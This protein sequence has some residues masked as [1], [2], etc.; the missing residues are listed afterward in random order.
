M[1]LV[2]G[3]GQWTPKVPHHSSSKL[4][5]LPHDIYFS[6]FESLLLIITSSLKERLEMENTRISPLK[7]PFDDLRVLIL[8]LVGRFS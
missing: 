4:P 2:V 1:D 3:L 5:L 6:W 8:F 7:Y